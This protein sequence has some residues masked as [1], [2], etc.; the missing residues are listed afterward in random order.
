MSPALLGLPIMENPKTKIKGSNESWEQLEKEGLI[1][2]RHK[3]VELPFIFIRIYARR[4]R[5]QGVKLNN[6][7]DMLDEIRSGP[8]WRQK[9]KCDI[10][11]VIL[12]ILNWCFNRPNHETFRLEEV[13]WGVKG[14]VAST[15]LK[16]PKAIDL[17]SWPIFL[18][19]TFNPNEHLK[20]GA[21]LGCGNDEFADS[22]I[23][24]DRARGR[25][26][27]VL[28]IKSKQ[29]AKAEPLTAKYFNDHKEKVKTK[30]RR[31]PFVFIMVADMLGD[32]EA[33]ENEI[34]ITNDNMGELYGRWLTQRRRFSLGE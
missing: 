27:V 34:I 30:L 13:F 4:L 26:K 21:F 23:V 19:R 8:S 1:T 20:E 12:Q 2:L 5:D 16:V 28:A 6:L 10:A 14:T 7:I 25:G 18:D 31:T 11:A 33:D 9:E 29:R 32:I 24:F 22:W 15:E 3:Y 17:D